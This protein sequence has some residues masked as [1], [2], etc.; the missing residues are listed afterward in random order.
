MT[1]V[2]NVGV[3]GAGYWGKKHVEEYARIGADVFVADLSDENLKLCRER[4]GAKTTKNYMDVLADDKV[5]FVSVCTPNDSHYPLCKEA[6]E[7]GK[8]V[9]VEKPLCKTVE[10]GRDLI[11][12]A[13][14]NEV[15][16][17]VGHVFRFNC[18]V[19]KIRDM[20]KRKE[21]GEIF[22]AKLKWTN[23]EPVFHDRDV[24]FDLAPHP[25][26]LVDYLFGK[27]PDE[28]SCIGNSFRQKKVLEAAFINARIEDVLVSIEL[29]WITP[30]KERSLVLV[31]SKKSAFV[32][33]GQQ[34]I[35]LYDNATN[36]FSELDIVANN[37]IQDELLGFI[38]SA[39]NKT[40]S[41]A[42]AEV[43]L[44]SIQMIALAEQSNREKKTLSLKFA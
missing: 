42:D 14:R 7:A 6:L 30:K 13:L 36:V 26:D 5:R 41:I 18:A 3:I 21:F 43:G 28:I 32:D 15:A 40:E 2:L 19:N 25:F 29:S 8:H 35:T 33:L 16:L 1:R 39:Q 17:V 10:E 9:L 22:M 37:T 20:L 23:L 34:K 11:K 4:F 38:H 31:G 12:T 27:T 44:K 24:I